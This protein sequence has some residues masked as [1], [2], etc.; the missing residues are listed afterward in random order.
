MSCAKKEC[1]RGYND[2]DGWSAGRPLT[3]AE[4]LLS[5]LNQSNSVSD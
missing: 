2:S 5:M 1:S 4:S 3:R